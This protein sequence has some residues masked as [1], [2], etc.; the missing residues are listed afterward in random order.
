MKKPVKNKSIPSNQHR[1]MVYEQVA[2]TNQLS[3]QVSETETDIL[4]PKFQFSKFHPSEDALIEIETQDG[5]VHRVDSQHETGGHNHLSLRL[6]KFIQLSQ[7]YSQSDIENLDGSTASQTPLKATL[8]ENESVTF[9]AAADW[10]V[11]S[12][13]QFI[14]QTVKPASQSVAPTTRPDGE[15]SL[16][17][18]SI[19]LRIDSG[20][21]QKSPHFIVEPSTTAPIPNA[22]LNPKKVKLQ[23]NSSG[24]LWK[25]DSL[26]WPAITDKLLHEPSLIVDKIGS[27]VSKLMSGEQNRLMVTSALRGEG[28]TTLSITIARWARSQNRQV[29]LVDADLKKA[30]LTKSIGVD[31]DVNWLSTINTPR[32]IGDVI[33]QDENSGM[34]LMPL[35]PMNDRSNLPSNIYQAFAKMLEPIADCF[36][37]IV[38]DIGTTNQFLAETSRVDVV[39]DV[40]MLVNDVTRTPPSEFSRAKTSLLSA[41]ISKMIVAENFANSADQNCN[42]F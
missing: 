14:G 37:L 26:Q 21:S 25:V 9:R 40:A 29:L 12:K 19:K 30:A 13:H 8:T 4:S 6:Q 31:Q 10:Q 28:C 27:N 11:E 22:H 36:D 7:Q 18:K 33:I 23:R 41:G 34:F 3:T 32:N 2:Y 24:L 16:G 42:M 35:S 1:P 39:A 38:M 5:K 17:S 15:S 20:R